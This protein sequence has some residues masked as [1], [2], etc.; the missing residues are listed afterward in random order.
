MPGDASARTATVRAAPNRWS[1]ALTA[2]RTRVGVGVAAMTAAIVALGCAGVAH[3]ASSSSAARSRG[4]PD[5]TPASATRSGAAPDGSGSPP[6]PPAPPAEVDFP[7]VEELRLEGGLRLLVAP[8]PGAPLVTLALVVGAPAAPRNSSPGAAHLVARTLGAALERRLVGKG[9]PAAGS[10]TWTTVD[11]GAVTWWVQVTPTRLGVAAAALAEEVTQRTSLGTGLERTRSLE[12]EAVRGRAELDARFAARLVAGRA[13]LP[14]GLSGDGSWLDPSAHELGLV[15]LRECQDW[16]STHVVRS[17]A[18]IVVVGDVDPAAT[19][20]ELRKAF[21]DWK[22]ASP[23]RAASDPPA[24]SPSLTRVGEPGAAVEL[25]ARDAVPYADVLVVAVTPVTAPRDLVAL[26]AAATIRC[27]SLRLQ[28]PPGSAAWPAAS[29]R[30]CALEVDG[31]RT[32]SL[33]AG[34]RVPAEA[35][36]TAAQQLTAWSDEPGERALSAATVAAAVRVHVDRLPLRWASSR[37]LAEELVREVLTGEAP[38][39]GRA[40]RDL[41]TALTVGD[42]ARASAALFDARRWRLVVL[43]DP[44]GLVARLSR[45]GPLNVWAP[46]DLAVQRSVAGPR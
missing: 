8:R 46:A 9:V 40:E 22:A 1:L 29:P 10:G 15:S 11:R 19:G 4:G 3:P 37:A 28:P 13:S 2:T 27:A 34:Q 17:A 16:H 43:G 23:P 42:V 18:S 33:V 31:D 5:S 24:A 39:A 30:W 41:W 38:D 36:V 26:Q 35:A 44:D 12:V 6:P 45:L 14:P 25:L 21:L 20:E 32:A 7:A